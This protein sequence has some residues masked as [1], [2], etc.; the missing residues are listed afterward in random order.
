[1]S[2][3]VWVDTRNMTVGNTVVHKLQRLIRESGAVADLG[4]GMRVALK[5]NTAEEG[6]P[7]AC[8]PV[9]CGR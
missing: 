4:E 9:F 5:V 3:V 1:M 6:M 2:E 7:T 8:A